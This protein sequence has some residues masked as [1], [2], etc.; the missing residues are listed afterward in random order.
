MLRNMGI[1]SNFSII[2]LSYSDTMY[3]SNYAFFRLNY[4]SN[5]N[6]TSS[7]WTYTTGYTNKTYN[8]VYN[9]D[10]YPTAAEETT[11]MSDGT[12]YTSYKNWTYE[13]YE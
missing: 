10:D 12:N 2:S 8:Y 7:Q 1:D 4:Y 3:F 11:D 5:N 13:T 6:I 9:D